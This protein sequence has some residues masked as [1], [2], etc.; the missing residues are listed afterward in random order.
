MIGTKNVIAGRRPTP[1][2]SRSLVDRAA[3]RAATQ[4]K[5]IQSSRKAV[6]KKNYCALVFLLFTQ[7][8]SNTKLL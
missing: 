5:E 4:M 3:R 7:C 1:R 6:N 8:A 2:G